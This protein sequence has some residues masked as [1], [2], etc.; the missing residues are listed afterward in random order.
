MAKDGEKNAAELQGKA[1]EMY[2]AF[3]SRIQPQGYKLEAM[4]INFPG[5]ILG[6]VGFILNWAPLLKG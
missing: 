4:I 1:R 2:D 6:D 5:G 3:K